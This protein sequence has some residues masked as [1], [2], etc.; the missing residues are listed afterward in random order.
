MGFSLLLLAMRVECYES[1]QIAF[2]SLQSS[3][4]VGRLPSLRSHAN[5]VAQLSEDL[6]F[7]HRKKDQRVRCLLSMLK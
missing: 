6:L 5:A 7:L 2:L 1:P 3:Q 4:A